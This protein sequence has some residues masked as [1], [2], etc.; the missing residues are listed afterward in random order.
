M[1][2]YSRIKTNKWMGQRSLLKKM[3]LCRAGFYKL[4]AVYNVVLR[5]KI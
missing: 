3:E 5:A 4:I 1:K 2:Q